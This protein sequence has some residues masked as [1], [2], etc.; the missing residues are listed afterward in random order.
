MID[1]WHRKKTHRA[2]RDFWLNSGAPASLS[3]AVSKAIGGSQLL[4]VLN[5][6]TGFL[7]FETDSWGTEAPNLY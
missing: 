4:W 1:F 6:D 2:N 3:A 5:K 7:M